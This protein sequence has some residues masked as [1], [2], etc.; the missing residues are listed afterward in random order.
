MRIQIILDGNDLFG[1]GILVCH[2]IHKESVIFFG[3]MLP[4]LDCALTRERLDGNKGTTHPV[5]Y[6]A[7]IIFF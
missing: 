7:I 1:I 4:D 2:M 5:T 6:V 3:P